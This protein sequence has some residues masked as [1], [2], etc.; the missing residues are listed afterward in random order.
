[1]HGI[2]MKGLQEFVVETTDKSTWRAIKD[3]ATDRPEFYMPLEVYPDE[4]LYSILE[5]AV[6]E[7]E[8]PQDDLLVEFGIFLMK[9][10]MDVYYIYFDDEWD[11]IDVIANVEEA[12]H[13]SLRARETTSFTPP[14]LG[15]QRLNEDIVAV[16]YRSDRG[17]IALAEGLI[18]G[19]EAEYDEPLEIEKREATTGVDDHCLFVI[20]RA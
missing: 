3:E 7:L 19:I 5:V 18:R 9:R 20:R 8:T 13:E 11:A 14:K 1:M 2:V 12:I 15:I 16:E 17:L 6:E 4:E 10:L